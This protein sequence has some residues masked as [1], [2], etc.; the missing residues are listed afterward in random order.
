MGKF[1]LTIQLA[2]AILRLRDDLCVASLY[3]RTLGMFEQ[4]V[5][6]SRIA[7]AIQH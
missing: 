6:A 4:V 7:G 5:V 3:Q 1:D 2:C